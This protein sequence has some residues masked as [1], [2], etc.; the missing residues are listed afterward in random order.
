MAGVTIVFPGKD[1]NHWLGCMF[2]DPDRQRQGIGRSLFAYVE[3]T[4][5]G[6]S[7]KLETPVY[8]RSNHAFYEKKCGFT[9]IGE[10]TAEDGMPCVLYAKEY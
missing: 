3:K 8:A 1:G 4:F 5:P 9:K 7:W 2:T 10:Q 6:S